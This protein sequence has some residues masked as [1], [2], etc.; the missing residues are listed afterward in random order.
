[1][2]V[3]IKEIAK[4]AEVSRGTVDRVLN[5]RGKVREEVRQRILEIAR[6][7][8]YMPNTIAKSLKAKSRTINIGI[9]MPAPSQPFYKQI[10]EGTD[11]ARKEYEQN[12][13][14]IIKPEYTTYLN[15]E[16]QLSALKR[17]VADGIDALAIAPI[18]TEEVNRAVQELLDEQI[19]VVTFNTDLST[20]ERLCFIGQNHRLSGRVAGELMGKLFHRPA[21]I[22]VVSGLETVLAHSQRASSF[23]QLLQ[24]RYPHLQVVKTLYTL[25]DD[26]R[27]F[28]VVRDYVQKMPDI[29]GVFI[30]AGG[31]LGG[32]QALIHAG[33][34]DKLRIIC[35]DFL[36]D[37]ISFAQQGLV[38]FI[39]GQEPYMQGFL[40]IRVLADYL[41]LDKKPED[42]FIHTAIDVRVRDN[43]AVTSNSLY[44]YL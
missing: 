41:I 34:I 14:I 6:Q 35:Y 2:A 44:H 7:H 4:M 42:E 40:P 3:T 24:E 28:Q 23:S 26:S 43:I 38:D 19:P 5:N 21:R 39:I 37:M 10:K 27:A 16:E 30:C 15:V 22:L 31:Y 13:G 25:D 12:F 8:N 32:I 33:I 18:D 20:A 9:I 1:M 11:D 36:P 29:D 17:L